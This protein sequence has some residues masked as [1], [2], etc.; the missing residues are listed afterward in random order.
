MSQHDLPTPPDLRIL[1]IASLVP[2]EEHDPQRSAPL[3]ER[4]KAAGTWLNP[5]IVAPMGDGRFVILDGAN[6]FHCLNEL[7]Y[8]NILVQVVDYE[9]E[10]VE[11][12]TWHHILSGLSWFELLRSIRE[13][14]G[15]RVE[16]ASLLD[17]R[18]ALA[19]R[20]ILAYVV[21]QEQHVYTVDAVAE[22]LAE[23]NRILRDVVNTYKKR[24][25]LN[26]INTDSLQVAREQYPEAVAIIV[27]PRYE[28]VEIVVA[29]RDHAYLPPGITRH[30][31]HGRAMRLHYPLEAFTANGDTLEQKNLALKR[32]IQERSA[33]KRVRYY[34]EASYLFD[35]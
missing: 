6:R 25:I 18:V 24:S 3:I 8:P 27:F 28:P 10:V 13:L 7:G 19:Q 30:V 23:R 26:R 22:S 35:E 5:P 34:A 2:H 15:V 31:I 12:D 16:S 21:L 32:W 1:P 17:A 29:A 14:D 9:S 4:I 11:L 20:K 33:Q